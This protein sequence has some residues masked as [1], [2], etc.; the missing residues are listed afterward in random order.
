MVFGDIDL[1]TNTFNGIDRLNLKGM[2]EDAKLGSQ[3]A[4]TTSTG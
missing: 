1:F 4:E 2:D 3:I